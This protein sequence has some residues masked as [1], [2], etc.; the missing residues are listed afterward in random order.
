VTTV[1]LVDDHALVRAGLA[2]LIA[3]TDDLVVVGEAANGEEAVRL[4]TD[5]VPDVVVMDLSMP[6]MDGMTATRLVLK[7]HPVIRVLV[8]TSFSDE[9][10]ISQALTAGAVGYLLKDGDPYDVLSGIRS[11]ARPSGCGPSG[12]R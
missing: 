8:L 11:A 6:V 2:S 1:L 3:T 9:A 7:A 10:R 12:P 4:A 5:L